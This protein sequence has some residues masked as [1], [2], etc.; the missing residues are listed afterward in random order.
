MH[1]LDHVREE[2]ELEFQVEQVQAKE[3]NTELDQGKPRCI[4][5][6]TLGFS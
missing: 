5:P 4:P 1:S 2:P 6:I 3:T